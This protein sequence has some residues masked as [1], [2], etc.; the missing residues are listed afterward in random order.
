MC[1]ILAAI[2]FPTEGITLGN[3]FVYYLSLKFPFMTISF[4]NISGNC[5]FTRSLKI[6]L[7][8]AC[9]EGATQL[10][11]LVSLYRVHKRNP[12]C[13]HVSSKFCLKC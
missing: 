1:H 5:V 12:L 8:V 3:G 11:F 6:S 7:A 10:I 4:S 13:M 2:P 9:T